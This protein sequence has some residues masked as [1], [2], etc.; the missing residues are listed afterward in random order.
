MNRA[1]KEA[2]AASLVDGPIRLTVANRPRRS[3]RVRDLP[4]GPTAP[5]AVPPTRVHFGE[6]RRPRRW[7][8]VTA[9]PGSGAV[10]SRRCCPS[11]SGPGRPAARSLRLRAGALYGPGR[12]GQCMEPL[13]RDGP[14]Q[15]A[16]ATFER[17]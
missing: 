2:A 5:T 13:D 4:A 15:V 16:M 6:P 7:L 14:T 8:F 3:L 1:A 17:P 11:S 12:V 9:R 10:I